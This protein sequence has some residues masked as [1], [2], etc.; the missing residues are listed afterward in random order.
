MAPDYLNK[1]FNWRIPEIAEYCDELSL[2]SAPFGLMLLERI[3]LKPKMKVLDVGFG[4]GFPLIEIAQRLGSSST[5]YGIDMWKAASDRAKR[6]LNAYKVENV[7]IIEG[8]ASQMRFKDN[9]FDMVT[10]NLVIN[11]LEEQD[12]AT[13]EIYRVL[14]PGGSFH[15]AS[16]LIGHMKEFYKIFRQTLTELKMENCLPALKA[17]I[18]HRLNAGIITGMLKGAGF[19][20]IKIFES[21]FNMRFLN[22]SALLNHSFIILGFIDGWKA[23]IPDKDKIKFFNYLEHNLNKFAKEKGELKLTIPI[24]YFSAVK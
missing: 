10:A 20:K 16:N 4:T 15:A 7:K 5:V 2:W 14:K 12:K 13:G 3:P 19:K 11:N 22:G 8:D 1:S 23:V 21:S 18:E 24:L 17:N 6:K 9:F